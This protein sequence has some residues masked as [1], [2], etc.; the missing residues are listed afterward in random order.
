M[1]ALLFLLPTLLSPTQDESLNAALALAGD[2]RAEIS[3]ALEKVPD[4]QRK[5]MRWLIERMPARD[6]K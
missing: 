1:N 2:N 6:L 5:G 3:A 4:D